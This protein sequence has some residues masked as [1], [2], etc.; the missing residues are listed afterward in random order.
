MAVQVEF[1]RLEL[2]YLLDEATAESVRRA[3]LPFCVPD[4]HNGR[5]GRGYW[6]SSLYFDS[7]RLACFR[8]NERADGDRFKLRAR[9]YELGGDVHLEIK[10]KRGDVVRK[11]RVIVRDTDW[12]DATHGFGRPRYEGPKQERTLESFAQLLAQY[13]AEPQVIIEYEREAYISPRG[14]YARVSFDRKIS[15]FST[16]EHSFVSGRAERRA[17]SLGEASRSAPVVL[18]LK[19]ET[20]IPPFM[21]DV[22]RSHELHR[23]GLSKYTRVT[24]SVLVEARASDPW[25]ERIAHG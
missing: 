25:L 5:F 8:A 23:V 16:R 21:V 10:R 7:P 22:I 9:I 4:P 13:G 19:C 14:E 12:V 3:I 17:L 15:Y 2:K 11:S 18:E 6:I 20:Q 24:R 1:E